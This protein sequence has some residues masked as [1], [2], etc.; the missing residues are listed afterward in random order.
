MPVIRRWE[1]EPL[2]RIHQG[3]RD[4]EA[5][6]QEYARACAENEQ[7][8][9]LIASLCAYIAEFGMWEPLKEAGRITQV[10]IDK[11]IDTAKAVFENGLCEPTEGK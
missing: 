11:I 3:E 6:K 8:T 9:V 7:S 10:R 1:E 2:A 4:I 5:G